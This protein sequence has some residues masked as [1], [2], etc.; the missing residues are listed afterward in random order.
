MKI[1]WNR[2]LTARDGKPL[3]GPSEEGKFPTAITLKE[4]VVA[5]LDMPTQPGKREISAS[6]KYDRYKVI[7]AINEDLALS[8]KEV[9]TC[10]KAVEEFNFVPMVHGQLTDILD[11]KA[12]A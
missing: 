6:E 10:I 3:M 12:E 11:A 1:D 5:A 9:G 4:L 2:T 8:T 7:K